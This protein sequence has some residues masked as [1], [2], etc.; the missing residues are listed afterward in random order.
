MRRAVAR[1][2]GGGV[3]LAGPTVLAFFSGGYFA[4]PRLI[5][6]IVAWALVLALAAAGPAPLP[7]SRAGWLA[8]AGLVAADRLERALVHLGAAAG[9]GARERRAARALHRRAA[10]GGR[11]AAD[12]DGG[13]GGRA[14][15]GGGHDVVIGYG[16]AGRLLPGLVELD[17]SAAPAGGSSSR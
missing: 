10:R 12:R 6:A 8:L 16:L 17:R 11:R 2:R 1:R 9:P 3:L 5:A 15:A 14:G 13:A 7:R 4:Q